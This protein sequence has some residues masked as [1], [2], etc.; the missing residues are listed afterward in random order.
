M[1]HKKQTKNRRISLPLQITMP[2]D[3]TLRLKN[4]ARQLGAPVS[5]V[6]REAVA[7]HLDLMEAA[8]ANYRENREKLGADFKAEPKLAPIPIGRPRKVANDR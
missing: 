1:K 2:P 7:T 3:E 5:G 6:I 8:M 4:M